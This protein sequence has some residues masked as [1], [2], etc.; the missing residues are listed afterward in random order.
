MQ[1]TLS[2]KEFDE[3]V[4]LWLKEQ[5]FTPDNY[6]ITTRVIAGRSDGGSGTRMT[7]DLERK[8]VTPIF[9]ALNLSRIPV[10][11]PYPTPLE[12]PI[13]RFGQGH[14]DE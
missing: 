3:A 6:D 1:I 13:K 9:D 2:Q 8:P 14:S 12:G 7:V 10:A 5:G 4:S 11:E